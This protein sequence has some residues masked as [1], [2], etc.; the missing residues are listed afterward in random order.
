MDTSNSLSNNFSSNESGTGGNVPNMED[1]LASLVRSSLSG[2]IKLDLDG[3]SSDH[4]PQPE[5]A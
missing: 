1:R 3:P 5:L 2:E 4:E